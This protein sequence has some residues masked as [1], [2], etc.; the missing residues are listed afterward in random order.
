[1]N[2]IYKEYIQFLKDHNIDID[3]REGYY[4]LDNQII[5]AYDKQGNLHKLFR[6]KIDDSL[7]ITCE[8]YKYKDFEIESWKETIER[9]KDRLLKLEKDSLDLIQDSISKYSDYTHIISTS[10]GKDSNLT[11]Y[12]VRS[13]NEKIMCVFSNTS[14]DCADTYKYIKQLKNCKILNPEE[15]FYEW[16]HKNIIP[17]RFSRGCCRVFKEE[18]IFKHY[19]GQKVLFFLGMR[20]AE[21]AG[22][23]GY[24]D[25]WVNI[26]WSKKSTYQGILPIRKW[27]DEDVWLYTLWKNIHI[28]TK[29]KK[30]Y[31]RVGCAIACPFYT[32]STWVLDKYWY[33]KGYERW[34]KI[35]E[36]DFIKNFKWTILNCT[37]KEYH[38]NWNGGIVRQEP[39]DEVVQEFADYKGLDIEIAKK[40]F[41]HTCEECG[42]KVYHKD[43]IAMNLKLLGRNTK[44]FYCKQHLMDGLGLT[45]EQWKLMIT[46]FKQ[47]G[48]DLF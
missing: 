32:K 33:P 34:H 30:G 40:Y 10:G 18:R 9:N 13:I 7:N 6:L 16:I 23:S 27:S 12:L 31:S 44:V 1:M 26:N 20:N 39:T 45:K 42:K 29:Y 17:S 22:R 14:L 21:S 41:N 35:L 15:G 43:V 3:I 8:Q 19:E 25:E 4:W 46:D 37:I 36:D 24:E 2:P 38:T 28:N 47:T 5:K 11:M 48:C